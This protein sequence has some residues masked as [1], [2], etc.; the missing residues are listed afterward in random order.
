MNWY[1]DSTTNLLWIKLLQ[2]VNRAVDDY[3]GN[4][5]APTVYIKPQYPSGVTCMLFFFLL[6]L[7]FFR[8]F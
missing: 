4:N 6:T 7:L 3:T 1:W 8:K 2:T 5:G